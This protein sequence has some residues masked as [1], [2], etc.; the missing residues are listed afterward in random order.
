[1]KIV[2]QHR[3]V[4]FDGDNYDVAWHREAERR[5]LP[6]L[7]NTA[8]ALPIIKAKKSLEIFKKFRV[9]S[10]TEVESRAHIFA[11]KYCKQVLI[12]AETMVARPN[13]RVLPAAGRHQNEL[14]TALTATGAAKVDDSELRRNLEEHVSLVARLRK[15]IAA[16]ETAIGHH[17][18]EDPF[19]HAS[20]TR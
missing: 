11:E 1:Q 8:D 14:A 12:G 4:L 2:K 13:T 16:L 20:Y 15:A 7:R 18:G 6:N 9:L 17:N 5:G 3:R 10:K 19:E